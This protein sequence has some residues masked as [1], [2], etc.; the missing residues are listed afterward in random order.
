MIKFIQELS[1]PTGSQMLDKANRLAANALALLTLYG[2]VFFYLDY[3]MGYINTAF[4]NLTLTPLA[5]IAIFLLK[6][7]KTV[8]AKV[9][10]FVGGGIVISLINFMFE[11]NTAV[12][13]FFIPLLLSLQVIFQGKEKIYS[14]SLL[15]IGMIVFVILLFSDY[16]IEG[17]YVLNLLDIK[18]Q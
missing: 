3:S 11:A 14:K 7:G 16:R 9:I 13:C 10:A 6:S 15:I 2:I 5:L 18:Y 1:P 4:V 8:L 12:I 17:A